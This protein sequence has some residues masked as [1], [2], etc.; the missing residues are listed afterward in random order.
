MFTIYPNPAADVVTIRANFSEN[1][2][3]IYYIY[4]VLGQEVMN[5]STVPTQGGAVA[6]TIN[7]KKLS[8]GIYF[9]KADFIS[10]SQKKQ[11][12]THKLTIQK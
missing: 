12:Y 3:L 10:D 6:E 5:A 11:T 1:G 7:V 8:P 2:N 4:N 9:I